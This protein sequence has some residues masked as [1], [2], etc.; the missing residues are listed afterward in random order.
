M[1][2][3]QLRIPFCQ[4][5]LCFR[6]GSL[7][8]SLRAFFCISMYNQVRVT[9]CATW[10]FPSCCLCQRA[11]A[12][13]SKWSDR[14]AGCLAMFQCSATAISDEKVRSK[15]PSWRYVC[16]Y[17]IKCEISWC[18]APTQSQFRHMHDQNVIARLLLNVK[19]ISSTYLDN[20]LLNHRWVNRN[21]IIYYH[22]VGHCGAFCGLKGRIL[23]AKIYF[24]P[25]K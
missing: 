10:V 17:L 12:I 18:H 16:V 5:F 11:N 24:S 1:S 23:R 2:C 14:L 3:S 6:M 7:F 22:F 8:A 4:L 15:T 19:I 25:P 9:N 20:R 13:I 21:N